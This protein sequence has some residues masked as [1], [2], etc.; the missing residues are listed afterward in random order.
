VFTPDF[1]LMTPN[2]LLQL[3]GAVLDEMRRREIIRT[4]NNPTG[5]YAE[6]LVADRLHLILERNS[7]K[8]Y[9]AT[10]SAGMRYQIKA[11]EAARKQKAP[12]FS[13][14]RELREGHFDFLVAVVFDSAWNL[15]YAALIPHAHVEPLCAY[16]ARVNGHQMRL[17]QTT[18]GTA[19]VQD[20]TNVLRT[21]KSVDPPA[22]GRRRPAG[23]SVASWC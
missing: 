11:R 6:W 13:V 5:D 1:S 16:R 21:S 4:R 12:L 22:A 23:A 19:G 10:D 17:A 14:M 20:I 18:L 7:S 9:D 3:H 8:G 2:D 15:S